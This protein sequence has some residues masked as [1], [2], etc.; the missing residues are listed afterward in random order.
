[1]RVWHGYTSPEN[2]DAYEELLKTEVLPGIHRVKGYCGA[3]L[4]RKPNGKESRVHHADDVG[5]AG[6]H[7]GVRW[8]R[9]WSRGSAA[10]SAA[11]AFAVRCDVRALRSRVGE[12]KERR[13]SGGRF[14]GILPAGW[15]PP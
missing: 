2:A 8:T 9:T 11:T 7:R 4:L 13:H 14:A 1:M 12:V 10:E 3:F 15:K 5:F 6:R